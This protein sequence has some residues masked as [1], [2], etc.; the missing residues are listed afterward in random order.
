MRL[1]EVAYHGPH[2]ISVYPR[3]FP[4][5]S[6][7]LASRPRPATLIQTYS[8][9]PAIGVVHCNPMYLL[10]VVSQLSERFVVRCH[11][12]LSGETKEAARPDPREDAALIKE[13]KVCA[14]AFYLQANLFL[15]RESSNDRGRKCA[16]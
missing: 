12:F 8:Q 9:V 16:N 1:F 7:D 3:F 5:V 10:V 13:L 2:G 4:H 6:A 14:V 11:D 15:V